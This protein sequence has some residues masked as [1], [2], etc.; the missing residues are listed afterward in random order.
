MCVYF[1]FI[2]IIFIQF[3]CIYKPGTDI[4]ADELPKN[5]GIISIT[6]CVI[7]QPDPSRIKVRIMTHKAPIVGPCHLSVICWVH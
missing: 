2:Y 4:F 1:V 7:F 5:D 6:K 3:V